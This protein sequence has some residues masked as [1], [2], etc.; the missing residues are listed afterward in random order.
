MMMTSNDL[1][2]RANRLFYSE[3]LH[4]LPHLVKFK[5]SDAEYV[6]RAIRDTDYPLKEPE[7][8]LPLVKACDSYDDALRGIQNMEETSRGR[9]GELSLKSSS[10]VFFQP[11][12]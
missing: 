11:S 10:Y 1:F 6:V 3:I 9:V 5:M 8:L 12:F 4:L 2:Q 7:D